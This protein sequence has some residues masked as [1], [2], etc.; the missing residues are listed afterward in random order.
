MKN[1]SKHN[2]KI[3]AKSEENP[4]YDVRSEMLLQEFVGLPGLLRAPR[5]HV[6]ADLNKEKDKRQRS[7]DKVSL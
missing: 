4:A 1:S 6:I 7:H 3:R 5:I 2:Y